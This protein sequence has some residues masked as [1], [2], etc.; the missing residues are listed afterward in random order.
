MVA[1]GHSAEHVS[2]VLG[3][4]VEVLLDWRERKVKLPAGNPWDWQKSTLA[5]YI[6]SR[7]SEW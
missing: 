3:D 4:L 6:S 7:K 2:A 5:D 1:E